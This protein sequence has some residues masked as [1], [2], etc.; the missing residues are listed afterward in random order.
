M[1]AIEAEM[2]NTYKLCLQ[3][4]GMTPAGCAADREA[5]TKLEQRLAWPPQRSVYQSFAGKRLG[6]ELSV[7]AAL[8]LLPILFGYVLIHA[9]L[10]GFLSVTRARP[11]DGPI[12]H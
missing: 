2:A 12:R 3:Q 6:D 9:V 7:M 1:R 4:K 10:I 8:C 11:Q 5:Y